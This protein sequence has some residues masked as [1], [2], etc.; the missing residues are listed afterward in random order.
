[1]FAEYNQRAKGY[2]TESENTIYIYIY[3]AWRSTLRLSVNFSLS[4]Q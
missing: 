3:G 2:N 4:L 1:M